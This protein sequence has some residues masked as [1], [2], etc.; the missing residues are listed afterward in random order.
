M[1][2]LGLLD[3]FIVAFFNGER[4]T[5]AR[6][7]ELSANLTPID[8]SIDREDNGVT[9]LPTNSGIEYYVNLGVFGDSVPKTVSNALLS[10]Q[11]F[12]IKPRSI[13]TFRQYVS[14]VFSS[15]EKAQVAQQ[16]FK[17]L[18]ISDAEVLEFVNGEMSKGTPKPFKGLFY[19]CLL[20]TSPSPRD[21]G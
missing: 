4:V 6:S 12:R 17:E 20:Y 5:I 15:K 1:N 13:G 14:G 16:K 10:M 9:V 18:G 2:D 7:I 21:L 8:E 19:S 11:E 3:A